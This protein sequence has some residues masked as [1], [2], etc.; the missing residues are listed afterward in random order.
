[1]AKANVSYYIPDRVEEG[2]SL[3]NKAIDKIKADGA[4]LIITVDCGTSD[5]NEISYANSLGL[6]TIVLDHHEISGPLPGAIAVINT[7]RSDCRFPFKSLAG[8]GIVF[9]FIIA[10]RGRLRE[11]GFWAGLPYPNLRD[12][13]DLVALGTIGDISSLTDENRIFVKIGM[14]LINKGLRVGLKA[15]VKT[16]GMDR[17]DSIQASYSI[18]PRLNAAGRVA[19]PGESVNLLLTEDSREAEEIA[20]RLEGLN[21]ERQVLEREVLTDALALTAKVDLKSLPALVIASE[22]W[23]PGIIGIVASKLVDIYYRPVI[24]I[25][26]KNGIGKGSGRSISEFNLHEALKICG[27]LLISQ[28]GH[29]FAAGISIQQEKLDDFRKLFTSLAAGAMKISELMPQSYVDARCNLSQVDA[30]LVSHLSCLEPFGSMNPEPLLHAS[31]V[32]LSSLSVVGKRHLRLRA[33]H[34]GVS[35]SSIWF[36]KGHYINDLSSACHDI[37]FTPQM[38]IWNGT[39][40]LQLKLRDIANLS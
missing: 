3:N 11:E 34:E 27:P 18:I 14:D 17:V 39:S 32:Q 37:V 38:N 10:L 5:Y 29:R 9:N 16:S 26:L 35:R 23:H 7:N 2:Y 12:F 25:S 40:S 33:S 20:R 15:L 30:D 1:M 8:V 4:A 31:Q 36:G 28:G 22:R 19:S 21:R 6:D 13:L 24:L